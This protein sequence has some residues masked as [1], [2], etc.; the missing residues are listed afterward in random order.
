MKSTGCHI[1]IKGN[2]K[3]DQLADVGRRKYLLLF[4]HISVNR[5]GGV[6]KED[7]ETPNF[8]EQSLLGMEG[9]GESGEEEEGPAPLTPLPVCEKQSARKCG[10]HR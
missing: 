1:G 6:E 2:H 7:E 9:E 5:V 8:D 4:G 3:A 10:A